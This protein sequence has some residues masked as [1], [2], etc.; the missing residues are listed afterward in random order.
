M[1]VRLSAVFLCYFFKK[2][3]FYPLTKG[4][5]KAYNYKTK[6]GK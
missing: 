4:Y 1:H 2:L 5:I 6:W 3:C